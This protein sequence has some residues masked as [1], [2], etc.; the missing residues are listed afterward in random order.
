MLRIFKIAQI[1]DIAIPLDVKEEQI[2][3]LIKQVCNNLPL[4]PIARVAGG[5]IRDKL[6]GKSS[7]DIDITVDGMTGIEFATA[8]KQFADQNIGRNIVSTIKDTEA[9]PEQIKNLAVAF[10]KIYEQEVEILN[11][12]GN[13][14]YE[15]GNRNP[16]SV[17]HGASAVDDSKR[18]DL[19]MNAL[20]YNINTGKVEDYV[21]GY[22]DL[23][24]MLLRT[25]LDP[26]MT[27]KDDPL[28]V[29]RILRFHSRYKNSTIDPDV[30]EAMRDPDVQF[31]ITRRLKNASETQGIVTERT[32]E[33]FRKIMKGEQPEKAIEIM[34]QTGLLQELLNLPEEFHPLEMDQQSKHHDLNVIT[35]TIEVLKNMNNVAKNFG[36]DDNERMV[37]NIAS[38]FHDLG[39]LDPRSHVMKS[40]STWGYS[41]NPDHPERMAHE[42]S[43]AKVWQSFSS[44][45]GMTNE[46][47]EIVFDVISGHMRPH[48]H[49]EGVK[50]TASDKQLRRYVRKNPIWFFQ[51]MHA[52][53]DSMS[54]GKEEDDGRAYRE[55]IDR[56]RLLQTQNPATSG[57]NKITHLLRGDEIINY[58]SARLPNIDIRPPAGSNQSYIKYIQEKILEKQDEDPAFSRESAFALIEQ[59]I[60]A[61]ELNV[62]MKKTSGNW[63]VQL[64]HN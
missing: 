50:N 64:K 13:E 6:L 36:V 19:T 9:R 40:D 56:I 39:K 54:K 63:L 53:A 45:I 28:R 15:Q 22:Q 24:N 41:G 49:I 29:L 35:H 31:Q 33:E 4:R 16:I 38:L 57:M 32:A 11:L 12:R 62:F 37:L 47:K 7:K 59:I 43:S 48:S 60:V 27:F 8:I 18:R 34:Y 51:Y 10:L 42:N 23:Q 20:F 58:V 2:F 55:N 61:G 5:W 17:Q 46:E 26:I 44:A 3:S 30:I 14:V 1:L 25:P 52:L 21:G